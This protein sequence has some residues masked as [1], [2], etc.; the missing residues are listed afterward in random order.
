MLTTA[1]ANARSGQ[2]DGQHWFDIHAFAGCPAALTMGQHGCSHSIALDR[3]RSASKGSRMPLL[4]LRASNH[5][6]SRRYHLQIEWDITEAA[7]NSW[8][9]FTGRIGGADCEGCG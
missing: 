3:L 7:G 9:T 5:D 4:A 8:R 6:S 1:A 2:T